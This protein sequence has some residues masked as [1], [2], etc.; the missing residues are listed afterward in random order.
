M[1]VKTRTTLTLQQ[2]VDI[3]DK[4]EGGA[5]Q[6]Q[7]VEQYKIAQATVSGIIKNG[8]EIRTK[9]ALSGSSNSKKVYQSKLGEALITWI[10]FKRQRGHPVSAAEVQAKALSVNEKLG[11][12]SGFKV[13]INIV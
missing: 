13:E 6:W 8:K 4:L 10:S 5:L 3:L 2:K 1:K 9:F 7:V 12:D 11:G